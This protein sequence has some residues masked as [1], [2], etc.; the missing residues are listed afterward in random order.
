MVE[1][2]FQRLAHKFEREREPAPFTLAHFE[3]EVAQIIH[4][5]LLTLLNRTHCPN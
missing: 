4:F 1:L 3:N 5:Y 2:P